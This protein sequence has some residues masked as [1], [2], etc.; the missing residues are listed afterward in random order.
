MPCSGTLSI[1]NGHQ[2]FVIG[3]GGKNIRALREQSGAEIVIPPAGSVEQDADEIEI[4]VHGATDGVVEK[5]KALISKLLADVLVRTLVHY[6][7]CV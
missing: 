6:V 2:K 3:T 7:C 5:A 4:V 1:P